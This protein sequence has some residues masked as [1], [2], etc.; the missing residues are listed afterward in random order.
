MRKIH[1]I[2]I[3]VAL[4]GLATFLLPISAVRVGAS[5][6][7]PPSACFTYF[8]QDPFVN[9]VITFDASCSLAMNR[10]GWPLQYR[11]DF[12]GDG[13][14]DTDYLATAPM[15]HA[16]DQAGA[17]NVTLEAKDNLGITG[18]A[19]A[20][21]EVRTG[22]PP[23]RANAGCVNGRYIGREGSAITFDASGS[24]DPNGVIV[25]YEWDFDGDGIYEASSNSPLIQH[26]WGDAFEGNVTLKVTDNNGQTA[27]DTAHVSVW[28]VAPRVD[29]GP[30]QTVEVFDV[31]HFEGS[32][33]DPGWFETYT[34]SWDFGDGTSAEGTLTPTHTYSE[35]GEYGVTLTVTENN[36]EWGSRW[37]TVQVLQ[38]KYAIWANSADGKAIQW[39]G[40]NAQITGNVHSNGG[41]KISGSNNAIDGTVYYVSSLVISGSRDHCTSSQTVPL[42]PMPVQYDLSAYQSGGTAT[43]AAG[44]YQCINGN[45]SV[46]KSNT[47]LDG[48][49][50]VKGNVNLS[51]SNIKGAFTIVAEGTISISG[52][53]MNCTAYSGDLLFFSNGASLSISGS[54]STLGG[55][56]YVPLG[57]INISGS[58]SA[59]SGSLFADRFALSGSKTKITVR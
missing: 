43:Q 45:F 51:G 24:Q 53:G 9:E 13:V 47:V 42:R 55:I 6:S 4:L 57:Q 40:G 35:V 29:A 23:L 32:F 3:A 12:D 7:V 30:D 15:T 49:Y 20:S 17:Y 50:Y 18:F 37:M 39:S 1:G 22:N 19:H 34:F 48:L 11:W 33:V 56:I 59:I 26:T 25:L 21:V 58:N 36:G 38:K 28:E 14:W 54:N 44:K 46:S 52:S 41:I 16:Y 2:M 31:V 8:P 5:V 27:T 10:G